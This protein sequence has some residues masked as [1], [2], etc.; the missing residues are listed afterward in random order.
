MIGANAVYSRAR[1]RKKTTTP[2]L[3]VWRKLA[4]KM[5]TNTI[6]IEEMHLGGVIGASSVVQV[7]WTVN[8]A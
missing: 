4:L 8:I 5:L 7:I 1:A 2:Q 6:D 3:N